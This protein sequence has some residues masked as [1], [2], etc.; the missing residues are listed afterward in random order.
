MT[1]GT[2][3]TDPSLAGKG[4]L[5]G[6]NEL[7]AAMH[8]EYVRIYQQR[9]RAYFLVSF[10]LLILFMLTIALST[11]FPLKEIEAVVVTVDATTGHVVKTQTA[12]VDVLAANEAIQRSEAYEY[13]LMRNTADYFD[14][15]RLEDYVAIH[16][17]EPVN[18][19]FRGEISANNAESPYRKTGPRG[20]Q[21]V[22]I[23]SISIPEKNRAQV[24]FET[25]LWKDGTKTETRYW[26]ADFQFTFTGEPKL[27][28]DK[29]WINPLGFI[30]T[31]YNKNEQ[32]AKPVA[33]PKAVALNGA[34]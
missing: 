15:Q 33:P 34:Q 10:L 22:K 2:L 18:L 21:T 23:N 4:T 27:G 12:N 17:T 16:S 25:N 1:T 29:R 7:A 5:A 26:Q 6:D 32:L 13:I 3:T 19:Q 9:N 28:L 30:V 24:F 31:G 8:G 14:R 11:A 20:R